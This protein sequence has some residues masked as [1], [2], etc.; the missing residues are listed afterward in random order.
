MTKPE[1]SGRTHLAP[2]WI[3]QSPALAPITA[4][5]R[6][7]DMPGLVV[8]TP[9]GRAVQSP[10]GRLKAV[11]A[12]GW[13]TT[14][15]GQQR[16]KTPVVIPLSNTHRARPLQR[17]G[18]VFSWHMIFR[19]PRKESTAQ[20]NH[21]PENTKKKNS[22]V[23]LGKA[24]DWQHLSKHAKNTKLGAAAA[25]F[26]C[27]ACSRSRRARLA[28]S[29]DWLN[30]SPS[31]GEFNHSSGGSATSPR[32]ANHGP[33]AALPGLTRQLTPWVGHGLK[34]HPLW[35]WLAMEAN[36]RR[37][38]SSHAELSNCFFK[39]RIPAGG[40]KRLP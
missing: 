8:M 16:T 12:S 28:T 39:C 23:D 14:G 1:C 11:D 35:S 24:I 26:A 5:E 27:S 10:S 3:L 4:Q 13:F 25:A 29:L 15:R 33:P 18:F 34:L 21:M 20:E 31:F 17:G 32:H 40:K 2:G 30:H 36:S 22:V 9:V 38:E 7:E 6:H 37:Y 19:L